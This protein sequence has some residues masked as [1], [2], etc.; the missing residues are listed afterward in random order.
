MHKVINI[1]LS[2]ISKVI[3]VTLFIL[4]CSEGNTASSNPKS[5]H[6]GSILWDG[7]E[8]K[9][10][11]YIPPGYDSRD[12][13]RLLPLVVM[14]HGGGGGGTIQERITDRGFNRLAEQEGIIVVYPNGIQRVWNG[15]RS[16]K[17]R[18]MADVD[19]T[20]DVGFINELIEYFIAT[21][22]VDRHRVYVTGLSNGAM[23]TQRIACEM[24][25]KI[26]AIAPVAG[27]MH[28][29]LYEKCAP[30][31]SVPVLM[32]QG[33]SDPAM[34]YEGGAIS[35]N[36]LLGELLGEVI[37]TD[38]NIKFWVNHNQCASR[39]TVTWEPDRVPS[40]GTRVRKELYSSCLDDAEVVLYTIEGGGHTWP[41]GYQYGPES[42]IGKTSKDIDAN[43]V[44]WEFFKRHS[45]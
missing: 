22:P 15:G 34:P 1:A 29:D 8:R 23:M 28:V 44:I 4:F 43:V 35:Q 21:Y 25:G 38:D 10:I 36:Q 30:V 27:N 24:S 2:Y 16:V 11:A 13:V 31:A 7:Q 42:R 6:A 45:R 26:A 14:L 39:P 17:H 32:I 3:I 33:D 12:S 20:D 40:D 5:N 19:G 9:Y 18:P 37:S 41:G